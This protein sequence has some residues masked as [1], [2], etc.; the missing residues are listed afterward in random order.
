MPGLPIER[1]LK[2]DGYV[3]QEGPG[4][5]DRHAD[6]EFPKLTFVQVEAEVRRLAAEKPDYVYPRSTGLCGDANCYYTA[7]AP[8]NSTGEIC[9]FGQAFQNL[10]VP[11]GVM[12][13]S[14]GSG[15]ASVF[16]SLNIPATAVQWRWASRV[17]ETQDAQAPWSVAVAEADRV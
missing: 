17:Q 11:A 15:A 9:I 3:D 8:G 12:A 10:G 5:T 7:D 16:D 13:Q 4:N 1:V 14:E 6:G 2:V